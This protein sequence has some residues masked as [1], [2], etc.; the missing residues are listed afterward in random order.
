MATPREIAQK[1]ANAIFDRAEADGRV[2][3]KDSVIDE[4]ERVVSAAYVAPLP[5]KVFGAFDPGATPDRSVWVTW[6]DGVVLRVEEA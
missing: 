5:P 6:S 2:L 1:A 4:I 3:H